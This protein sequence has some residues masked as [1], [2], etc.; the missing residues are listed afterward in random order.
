MIIE[1]IGDAEGAGGVGDQEGAGA[2]AECPVSGN[3][4]DRVGSLHLEG[5]PVLPMILA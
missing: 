5:D 4:D 1:D 2:C 3:V